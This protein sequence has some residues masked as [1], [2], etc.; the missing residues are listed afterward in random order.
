MN[1]TDSGCFVYWLCENIL[2]LWRSLISMFLSLSFP[3]QANARAPAIKILEDGHLRLN[4]GVTRGTFSVP[5]YKLTLS[6]RWRVQQQHQERQ[7]GQQSPAWHHGAC[8]GWT[9]IA[10]GVGQ[11]GREATDDRQ[12]RWRPATAAVCQ[13]IALLG[14][15]YVRTLRGS[16]TEWFVAFLL[17]IYTSLSLQNEHSTLTVLKYEQ[18]RISTV[19]TNLL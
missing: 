10:A 16:E 6:L 9:S 14:S 18:A 13:Q 12:E 2:H 3:W 8:R 1:S 19:D 11:Q 7:R 15:S 17:S 5:R 4:P